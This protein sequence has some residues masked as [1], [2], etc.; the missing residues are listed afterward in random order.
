MELTPPL[1]PGTEDGFVSV[2]E[3]VVAA[4]QAEPGFRLRLIARY[5][6]CAWQD[7]AIRWSEVSG[8]SFRPGHGWSHDKIRYVSWRAQTECENNAIAWREWEERR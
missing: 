8:R 4:L 7:R 2:G 6:A 3:Y 1:C 5:Q